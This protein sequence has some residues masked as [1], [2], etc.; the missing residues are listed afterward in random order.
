MVKSLKNASHA[1]QAKNINNVV[2]NNYKKRN[3]IFQKRGIMP[4]NMV[5]YYNQIDIG[6]FLYFLELCLTKNNV[7]FERLLHIE[8]NINNEK[9]L[10]SYIYN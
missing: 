1:D 3:V 4:I 8:E 9:K 6:I 2:E 5:D 7:K 10:N